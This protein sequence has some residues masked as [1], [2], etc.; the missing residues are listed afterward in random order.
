MRGFRKFSIPAVLCVGTLA[1]WPAAAQFQGLTTTGNGSVLYFSSP[2]RPKGTE[3]TFHSKI[4]RWDVAGGIQVFAEVQ[5][6]GQSDGC[7]TNSFY[8][9]QVPQVSD[10]GTVV[11]YTASR[12]G[13]GGRFCVPV[14]TNQGT[15][16]LP[17]RERRL[18]GNIALSPSG[19]YAVTTPLAAVTDSFHIITDLTS[20]TSAAVAGAFNGSAQRVTD[21]ATIV[22]PQPSAV[23]VT[24]RSGGTRVFQTKYQVDDVII[25]RSGKTVVYVTNLA[26]GSAGAV[27]PGRISSIDL[28]SG[29]ET[30][31]TTGFAPRNPS[32]TSDGATV[33]FTDFNLIGQ[34]QQMY[35]IGIGGSGLRQVTSAN[36]QIGAAVVSGDGLTAYTI[37]GAERLVRIDAMSGASAELAATPPFLGAAYRVFPP[38]TTIAAVGSVMSLYGSGLSNTRQLTF[39]GQPVP[40]KTINSGIV[41]FQVPWDAPEGACQAIVQTDSPFEH[42]INLEVRILDPQFVGYPDAFLNH[43]GFTGPITLAAPTHPG[44]VIVAYMTGLGPV[45]STGQVTAPGFTCRFDSVPGT[46]MS[47]LLTY[48]P[49]NLSASIIWDSLQLQNACEDPFLESRSSLC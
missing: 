24:D 31:L 41:Q 15:I 21:D 27:Q 44:E 17:G 36:D 29:R 18:D 25:D 38:A 47:D 1:Q 49:R 28:T 26:P 48:P 40:F 46:L 7:V 19:R 11:A 34:G 10:D 3:Q 39:C 4:F 14:E 5:S 2:I 9:L 16:E 6:E 33:F 37:T 43:Q 23:I 35:A 12:P 13:P 42:G 8:Q 22:T 30:Q 32:L 45:D 20:G